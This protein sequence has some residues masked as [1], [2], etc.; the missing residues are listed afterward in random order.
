MD[1]SFNTLQDLFMQLGLDSD[2]AAIERFIEQHTLSYAEAIDA[3]D[4][5][6]PAQ[7]AFLKECLQADSDWAEV[8]DQLSVQLRLK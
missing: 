2:E 5:W 6:S 4:F 8:V 3:A 1:L 7:A